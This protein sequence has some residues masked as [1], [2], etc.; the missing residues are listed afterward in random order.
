[1]VSFTYNIVVVVGKFMHGGGAPARLPLS[2][3]GCPENLVNASLT[4]YLT[5]TS[6]PDG[7]D[8]MQLTTID[9]PHM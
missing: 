6:V 5:S 9:P 8:S 2:I 3:D 1:M 7:V 4:S